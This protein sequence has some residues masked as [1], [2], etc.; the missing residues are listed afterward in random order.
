MTVTQTNGIFPRLIDTMIHTGRASY[1]GVEDSRPML[2][3][4]L[5]QWFIVAIN[6]PI[7]KPVEVS[8]DKIFDTVRW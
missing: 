6:K 7:Y 5:S 4:T 8:H 1:D 3:V 2:A